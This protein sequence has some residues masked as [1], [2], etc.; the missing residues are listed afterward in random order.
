M[1]APNLQPVADN[2]VRRARRLGYVVGRDIREEL[3]HAGLPP[4]AW[5]DVVP[6]TPLMLRRGRYYF[7]SAASPGR[8]QELR[9]QQTIVRAVRRIVRRYRQSCDHHERREEGRF[10]F[11]RPATVRTEEG[12]EHKLLSRDLS[13]AGIRLVGTRRLL[14]QKVHV[15]IAGEEGDPPV[16]FLVRILWT[17]AVG[18]DLFENG[19]RFLELEKTEE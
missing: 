15:L 11:V 14:G 16:S 5:R 4:A 9:R 19:G 3:T 12:R 13:P 2:V 1:I 18:D 6:L 17:C 10:D 8:D 7:L